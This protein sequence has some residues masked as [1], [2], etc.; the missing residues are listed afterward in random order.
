MFNSVYVQYTRNSNIESIFLTVYK[1]YLPQRYFVKSFIAAMTLLN[2][3]QILIC[4]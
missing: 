4:L 3:L 2:A 1:Y